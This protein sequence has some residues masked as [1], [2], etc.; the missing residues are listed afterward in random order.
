MQTAP[1]TDDNADSKDA[2]LESLCSNLSKISRK[3]FK[4]DKSGRK[5]L[6][7]EKQWHAAFDRDFV[8]DQGG[9]DTS[10][11]DLIV[12]LESWKAKLEH[13]IR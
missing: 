3:F 1:S 7:F 5:T 8:E 12:K 9:P 11:E 2:L 6:L 13:H 4:K 10:V